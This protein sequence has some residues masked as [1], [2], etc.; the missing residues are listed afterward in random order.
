MEENEFE[1]ASLP[2]SAIPDNSLI[3]A[4]FIST[5]VPA[6]HKQPS[7]NIALTKAA[8]ITEAY[9]VAALGRQQHCSFPDG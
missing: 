3:P 8:S 2:T 5:L 9:S 4:T 1:L 7:I 6:M